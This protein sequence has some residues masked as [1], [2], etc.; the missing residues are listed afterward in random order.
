MIRIIF[1]MMV[2]AGGHAV[3]AQDIPAD[4]K[5]EINKQIESRLKEIVTPLVVAEKLKME[6]PPKSPT[7]TV[8]NLDKKVAQEVMK[9]VD[10]KYPPSTRD[11]H[12]K[13]AR[14][15][16]ILYKKGDMVKDLRIR[17]AGRK[18]VLSGEYKG[19]N[20]KGEHVVGGYPIPKVV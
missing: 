7:E 5:A 13:A 1:A 12:L 20:R 14:E 16:Y 4:V 17:P 6:F 8:A 2:V 9:Q 18:S 11:I 15:K 3:I 19:P 10:T